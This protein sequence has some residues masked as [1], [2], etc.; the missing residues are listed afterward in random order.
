MSLACRTG[1]AWRRGTTEPAVGCDRPDSGTGS[2]LFS[3]KISFDDF[4]AHL[5]A[6]STGRYR[7]YA[8]ALASFAYTPGADGAPTLVSCRWAFG[9][10]P[11]PAR[12]TV[13]Y[14]VLVFEERW[15]PAQ[16][17]VVALLRVLRGDVD[18]DV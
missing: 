9:D 12:A 1:T 6:T 7:P 16:G 10:E 8:G 4:Q 3:N 17:A 14:P 2:P 11:E 18:R 15:F 13:A 5:E